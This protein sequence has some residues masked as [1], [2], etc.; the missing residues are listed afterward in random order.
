MKPVG[1]LKK[2][3]AANCANYANN[4]IGEKGGKAGENRDLVRVVGPDRSGFAAI[5]GV[6][7][8]PPCSRCRNAWS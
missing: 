1:L 2:S 3:I 5:T 8:Q 4:G 7:Q 6:F